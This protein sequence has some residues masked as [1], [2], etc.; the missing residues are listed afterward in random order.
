MDPFLKLSCPFSAP[1]LKTG[2][3][4]LLM[5]AMFIDMMDPFL[6]LPCPYDGFPVL[7]G[8]VFYFMHPFLKL[9]WYLF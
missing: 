9:R 1:I 8:I 5:D 4:S 6:K 2:Y 3:L 7:K